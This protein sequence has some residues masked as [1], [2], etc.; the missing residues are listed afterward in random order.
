MTRHVCTTALAMAVLT[1][2]A[3]SGQ[4]AETA[5][6]SETPLG[7][8]DAVP[9]PTM[10][11]VQ[12][13][14]DEL[15]FHRWR[16]QRH[17]TE[18]HYRLLDGHYLRHA[19][20]T[21]EQCLAK[22][23]EIRKERSL[24]PMQGKAVLVLHGLGR[25]RNS[26]LILSKY[27]ERT[28]GYTVFNVAYPSTRQGIGNHAASLANIIDNLEGIEE[29][30]FVGHSLG[31]IVI[32]RYLAQRTEEPIGRRLDPR[33]K[34]FVMLGP[35]NHGS[36]AATSLADN[37]VFSTV[38]G[39]SAQELG[40]E[41]VWL[42]SELATPRCEFGIIAGGLGNERGF[43]PMLPGDDDGVV[44][45]ESARLAGAGDFLVVP[46]LHTLLPSDPRVLKGTLSFLAHGYFLS[47]DQRERVEEEKDEG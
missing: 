2:S 15:F 17:A 46:V 4:P 20:G 27:L 40:R 12:F 32:R 33:I 35:P 44:T 3:R 23:R 42:E 36:V 34:R 31:N 13:W 47:A 38:L 7:L 43:N 22:L 30:N 9:V 41:W 45:L 11:G 16:I 19:S 21:C 39:Q 37:R 28:G 24:P 18:G 6:S 14:A 29:I 25:T 5:E 10:G 1:L 8:V 26:M